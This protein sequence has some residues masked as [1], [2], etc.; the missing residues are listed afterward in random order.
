MATININM[1]KP[2]F[3][4]ANI[5]IDTATHKAPVPRINILESLL[6]VLSFILSIILNTPVAK[7]PKPNISTYNLLMKTGAK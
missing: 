3:G 7:R 1:T 5:N 2:T 4:K 6:Y